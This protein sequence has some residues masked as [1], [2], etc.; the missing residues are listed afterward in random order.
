MK[1]VHFIQLNL[2]KAAAAATILATKLVDNPS[3]CML[4]EPCTA[5]NKV[6]QVPASHSCVLA[7]TLNSRPRAAVLIP[8]NI[9]FVALDQLSNADCAVALISTSNGKVLLAS[10]YLDYNE[11]VVPT[12]LEKVVEYADN[13]R[14]PALF[15]FDSNAH[16]T[17]YGPDTNERGKDFEEFIFSNN[18]NVE[19]RG[20]TPTFHAF[21]HGGNI[22]THIDVTLSKHLVP[23]REWRVHDM[24]FNGSDHHTITWTLPLDLPKRPLVRPWKKAKWEVFRDKV[25]DYTFDIPDTLSTRKLDKLLGRWYKVINEALDEACPKREAMLSPIEMDWYGTDHKFLKNRAKRK[26]LTHRRSACPKH[27]KAFVRAKRAYNK[28]CKKGRKDSWRQFV[29]KTP[30]ESNMATLF[31]IA[32]H[33]DRR[34]INTLLKP[35]NTLSEPGADTINMLTAAHFP[36]ATPGTTSF[37]HDNSLQIDTETIREAHDWIDDDLVRKSMKQFKPNKAPGPDGL[38]PLVFK[39]LPQ[40]AIETLTLIYK[41]CISFGHTPKRWR[42]T[43]VVFLP[44]PGKDNYDVPK[45]YRP[46]SLS[47]FLLKTLERLVVWRM[48]K[49]MEDFPIHPM[50][51]GFTKGKC[52]ESAISNTT[53]YIEEFLFAKE[54]CLGLF[55]DISSAFDSISIDHIK[56]TLLEHNG[57][58]DMVEWYYSYLGRRYLEVEL[59]G[60]T[61]NLTTATGFPQGGVCSARFWL[62]AFDEAIHIINS[63]GVVGNGYADDCSAL[64]GGTHTHNMI[65]KM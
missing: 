4:T 61:V 65:E 29:E 46:I 24:E 53:D 43:K 9:S 47:N 55:L 28:A 20:M 35:D 15:S 32:Q 21:R 5:F 19:N 45:S 33:R 62:I 2:H 6:S 18:L 52:T 25:S 1:L 50:Q 22:D 54:H 27:R 26:Y 11:E 23:L 64:I 63:N 16:S 58:P 38:K 51:H 17:L 14:L 12:W 59:H 36:A 10:I 48:D 39:Y 40:N 49:D 56:N 7:T 44:K 42:E 37:K 41:A 13:K 60:E 31:K 3:I 30:N 8:R 57:T 34:S